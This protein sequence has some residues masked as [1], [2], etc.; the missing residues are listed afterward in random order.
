[1]FCFAFLAFS[2][3]VMPGS[4]ED[5]S[6]QDMETRGA[7]F[8]LVIDNRRFPLYVDHN[9]RVAFSRDADTRQSVVSSICFEMIFD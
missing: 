2:L 1:M 9:R 6:N 7:A 3:V 5:R 4:S 8:E